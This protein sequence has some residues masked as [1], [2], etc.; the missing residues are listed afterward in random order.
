MIG[1]PNSA[2]WWYLIEVLYP[3]LELVRMYVDNKQCQVTA[4]MKGHSTSV[5]F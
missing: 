5:H 4:L 1:V 2:H 3:R